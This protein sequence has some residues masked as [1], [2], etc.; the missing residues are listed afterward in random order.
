MAVCSRESEAL[1]LALKERESR[2]SGRLKLTSTAAECLPDTSLMPCASLTSESAE[3]IIL[4][5][6]TSSAEDSRAKTSVTPELESVSLASEVACGWNS[7]ES[8]ASYDRALSSWKTAQIWL[9]PDL[10]E[11]WETFPRQ[12]LM[13]NGKLYALPTSERRIDGSES[14]FL[15][16]PT[17]SM[18]KR[19]WGVG[20]LNQGRYS[21]AV[22]KNALRFGYKPPMLLLEW[23]M[24]YPPLFTVADASLLE[25]VSCPKSAN[26]LDE[27]S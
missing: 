3:H 26:G 14:S 8:F 25:T 7:T 24:G 11:F 9:T 15:P 18:G 22:I 13:R 27:E 12:G 19:G 21:Q 10:E 16:T 1:T 4:S 5:E 20:R 17:R 23:M 6:L 2:Q